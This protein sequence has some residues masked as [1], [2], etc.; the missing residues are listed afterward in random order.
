MNQAQKAIPVPYSLRE[1][2][3]AGDRF[4]QHMRERGFNVAD[5]RPIYSDRDVI[6]QPWLVCPNGA[7]YA[8]TTLYHLFGET[9]FRRLLRT[10]LSSTSCTATHFLSVCPDRA[11]CDHYLTFLQD[12]ELLTE[13]KGI[14]SRGVRCFAVRDIGHSL[15]WYL[16]EW[17][18]RMPCFDHL[19]PVRHGV[20]CY[21]GYESGDLDVVVLLEQS[22]LIIECKSTSKIR[23]QELFTFLKRAYLFR[24]AIALLFIDTT[25]STLDGLVHRLNTLLSLQGAT[26]FL[27]PI[28]AAPGIY[29]NGEQIYVTSVPES[30]DTSLTHV[31]R[32]IQNHT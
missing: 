6:R 30:L 8:D 2:V 13:E 9:P 4:I 31:L 16:A 18:R 7:I 29:W 27:E 5:T 1:E 14:W 23:T 24:P 19:V 15:E 22:T 26:S 12:Q 3:I 28:H 25:Q 21:R 17:F 32:S 11:E 10:A 20:T